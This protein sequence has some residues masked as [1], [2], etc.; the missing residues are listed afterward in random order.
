MESNMNL[1]SWDEL[2][3]QAQFSKPHLRIL[4]KQ[5]KFPKRVKLSTF[6]HAWVEAEIQ[7]WLTARAAERDAIKAA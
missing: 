7:S 2:P 3:K 6:R 1:I 4:E 5:G